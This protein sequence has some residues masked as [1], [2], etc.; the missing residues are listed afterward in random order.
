[1]TVGWIWRSLVKS[2]FTVWSPETL[3]L[4]LTSSLESLRN[5]PRSMYKI[6]FLL[7]FSSFS[8]PLEV[9]LNSVLQLILAFCFQILFWFDPHTRSY[10]SGPL[11]W[12]IAEW[13]GLKGKLFTFF[14][15]SQPFQGAFLQGC[16]LRASLQTPGF[17]C[18]PPTVTDDLCKRETGHTD[19]TWQP[20]GTTLHLVFTCLHSQSFVKL[21]FYSYEP[22]YSLTKQ[23]LRALTSHYHPCVPRSREAGRLIQFVLYP[24]NGTAFHL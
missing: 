19:R 6:V 5:K 9:N 8:G 17:L 23:F 1:M 3:F 10:Q 7:F 21:V 18:F 22:F 2:A 4:Q 12:S 15:Q 24:S 13:W 11:G 16:G 14:L 20:A